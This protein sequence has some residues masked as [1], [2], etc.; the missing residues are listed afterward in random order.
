M[1]WNEKGEV[2]M[3]NFQFGK[4]ILIIVYAFCTACVNKKEFNEM[5]LMKTFCRNWSIVRVLRQAKQPFQTISGL[6]ISFQLIWSLK[7]K[8]PAGADEK[9]PKI[10]SDDLKVKLIGS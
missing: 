9:I 4:N 1:F 8:N 10:I 7:A 3:E 2:S 6:L 5:R